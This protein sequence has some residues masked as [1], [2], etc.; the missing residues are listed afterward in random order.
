MSSIVTGTRLAVPWSGPPRSQVFAPLERVESL[1]DDHGRFEMDLIPGEWTIWARRGDE[2]GR[3][4]QVQVGDAA[5]ARE[6]EIV[7]I[8]LRAP[9]RL[10]GQLLDEAT[11]RPVAGGRIALDDAR[12]AAVDGRGQLRARWPGFGRATTPM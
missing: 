7:T 2:G 3:S 6:H 11:E 9:T 1:A 5:N 10:R 8:R 4:P 12:S